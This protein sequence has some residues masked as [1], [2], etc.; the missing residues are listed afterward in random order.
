MKF[1]YKYKTVLAVVLPLLILLS[2]KIWSHRTFKYDAKTW[3]EPSFNLSNVVTEAGLGNLPGHKL[4]VELDGTSP[5]LKEMSCTVV[6]ISPDS[7]LMSLNLKRMRD[8]IGPVLLTSSDPSIPARIWMLLSQT[9]LR[10]LYILSR[11]NNNEDFK[12]KFRPDT[13]A[14]PGI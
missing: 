10:N 1:I 14:G 2:V 7:I 12:S 3:A 5:E 9:G 4:I 6:H 13:T 11:S 8:N